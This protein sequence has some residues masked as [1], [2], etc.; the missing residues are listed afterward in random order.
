MGTRLCIILLFSLSLLIS[1]SGFAQIQKVKFNLV[2]GMNGVTVGKITGI[3]QD[4]QGYMWL[5][6]QTQTSITRFD[7]YRMTSFRND[8]SNPNSLGGTY[9]ECILADSS[10]AIW[11]GFY[12]MGLDRFDPVKG[13]FTHYR[14][15][16]EDPTSL[17]N[18]SVTAIL[19]DHKG[20]VWVGN[21]GGLDRLDPETGKFTHYRYDAQDKTSLSHNR[22]R[23]LYEDSF[24]TLWVGTGVPFDIN[25][26]DEGG[27]NRFDRQTG[28]FT[29]FMHD[30]KDPNS[31]INNKVRAIFEDSRGTFWVGT[32]GDGLHTMD[33]AKGTFTRH[34]YDPANPDRLSRPPVRKGSHF[35]HITFIAEDGAG[36]I[37][38]GTFQQGVSRLDPNT[39]KITR[40]HEEGEG[41]TKF[42]DDSGWISYT[43]RDGVLWISTQLN[44]LYRINPSQKEIPHT[45]M[46][47]QVNSFIEEAP[48]ILWMGSETGI[49]R[50]DRESKIIQKH[51]LDTLQ[52]ASVM[53]NWIYDIYHGRT[54]DFWVS[55]ESGLN[56]FN[57]ETGAFFRYRHDP[58]NSGSI[59]KGAVGSV[60][61]D[62]EG[63]YWVATQQ[64]LDR[65]DLK[66]NSFKHYRHD[67]TD[68]SS[69]SNNFISYIY[70]DKL[71]V[72]WV[73]TWFGGGVHLMDK[74]NGTFK[75]YLRD[76]NITTIYEDTQ[77]TL[78]IGTEIG[79]YRKAPR[80]KGF[81]VFLG[82]ASE[83]GTANIVALLEDNARNLWIA[84][85]SGLFR[86]DP[87]RNEVSS[88]GKR[89]GVDANR[90]SY[91]AGFKTSQGE[92]LFG[93][94][95]GFYAF[96]PDQI[97]VNS[98]PPE[99]LFTDF[100]IADQPVQPGTGG[101][102]Q[103]PVAHA[104][105]I[106]LNHNQDIFSFY[107]V[108]IHYS[109]PEENRHYY[110]LEGYDNAWREA[111]TEK[112]AY[113]FNVPDGQYLF[114]VKAV[115]S[116]GLWAEK[117]VKLVIAPPWWSTW[118]AY[119]LYVI[120]F[121]SSFWGVIHFRSRQLKIEKRLLEHKV[122]IRTAEVLQQKEEIAAQRDHLGNTLNI[123]KSTQ[124]QLI[125]SEKM[126]SLGELTAGIAHEIQNPLN[127]VNNFSEIS[128]ELCQELQEEV[129]RASLP[130][131]EKEKLSSVVTS[132][133][134][135]QEKIYY[136]GSRAEDI[137]KNM[138]LHSRT[139]SGEKQLTNI[140]ALADEYLCLA[141][142][143][144]R[145]KDKRFTCTLD[146]SYDPKLEKVEVVP[147]DIGRVLLNLYNN[148][149]YAVQQKQKLVQVLANGEKEEYKPKVSVTTCL[150]DSLVE[151]RVWDNGVGM[152]E[153]LKHKIFQPFFTTKPTGQ[154]TG[155]GLSLSYD[156][157]TKSHGGELKVETKEGEYSE[158]IIKLP[159]SC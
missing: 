57:P 4:P 25:I 39:Q 96:F 138:L 13:T 54:R 78:W 51:L 129:G 67:P 136:H 29:R 72:L 6:D 82:P 108:G 74:E 120:L 76:S 112:T 93:D 84:T 23:S 144:L 63:I 42:K 80:S 61:E 71:G 117:S 89:H 5:A 152:P 123:L 104:K 47:T 9:P 85:Y 121:V 18:D 41:E 24:G 133:S 83:M 146:T 56:R 141:Y 148:A 62:R 59:S 155:L 128:K 159:C 125:Q 134:L 109:N 157:I 40:Y 150:V 79:L 69:L 122:N 10:G 105:R 156:I 97:T 7:G 99:I 107:F 34:I 100:K 1:G 145:A 49:I 8:P 106:A 75:S 102:L 88:F 14:H 3:T 149:F 53:S 36:A 151:I 98:K 32:A 81:S 16:P 132:L 33:R 127:F 119:A 91:N 118:W 20:I 44:N 37:W 130:E 135:N 137:V 60:L 64:G 153:S 139:S 2:E 31:L 45:D 28:T 114:R 58:A 65:L 43:S 113:Y 124:A 131:T 126:A 30:P 19:I 38:I 142:H 55:S 22:V 95:T 21:Y 101:P 27:L 68:S 94:Y 48:G 92:L 26:P 46:G 154:G 17:S 87:E 103:E 77:G 158:F 111:G 35:D 15:R 12:G 110:K 66:T 140:N 11:I 116:E 90:L 70:E 73:G 86:V 50:Y 115:S 143:G 52:P 147:Q